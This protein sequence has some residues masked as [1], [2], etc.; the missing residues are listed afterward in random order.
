[1]SH[2]DELD[3][4]DDGELLEISGDPSDMQGCFPSSTL[5]ILVV[6]SIPIVTL[7]LFS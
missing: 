5:L 1:M 2:F 7:Y 6:N 3:D 4:L